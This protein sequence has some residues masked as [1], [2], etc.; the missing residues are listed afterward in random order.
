MQEEIKYIELILENCEVIRIDGRYIGDFAINDIKESICRQ[1]CN[2]IGRI[3]KCECFYMS[4]YRE[5]NIEKEIEFTMGAL[6]EKAKPF[7]RLSEYND[8]TQIIICFNDGKEVGVYVPWD[9][10]SEYRN[11]YQ[12]TCMSDK[13]DLYILINKELNIEDIWELSEINDEIDFKWKMFGCKKDDE[14][15]VI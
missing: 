9:E 6:N 8:I 3:K 12:K 14:E 11:S 2:Y 1:G 7:K 13:G 5:E 4:I 15:I 10:E